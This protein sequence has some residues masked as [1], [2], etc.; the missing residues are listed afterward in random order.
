[1]KRKAILAITMAI[2]MVLSATGCGKKS[3]SVSSESGGE[4]KSDGVSSESSGGRFGDE[5][6]SQKYFE[7]KDPPQEI[8]SPDVEIFGERNVSNGLAL[9]NIKVNGQVIDI[10]G[11]TIDSFVE[12]AGIK[13]NTDCSFFN[14][15]EEDSRVHDGVFWFG[16]GYGVCTNTKDESLSFTGTHIFIEALEGRNIATEVDP[17]NKDRYKIRSVYSSIAMSKDDFD[18]EFAGHIKCGSKRSDVEAALGKGNTSRIYTYYSNAENAMFIRY[19][20]DDTA[21]EIYLFNDFDYAQIKYSEAENNI[22]DTDGT[23]ESKDT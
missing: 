22:D 4:K 1:M 15:F 16:G 23:V 19:G 11:E 8:I 10:R 13:R 6:S 20:E 9:Y 3:D 14:P 21:T 17:E 5:T 7:K 2:C 18:I 12:M